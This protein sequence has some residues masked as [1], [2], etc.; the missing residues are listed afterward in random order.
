[1]NDPQPPPAPLPAPMPT[2]R[3]PTPPLGPPHS[4]APRPTALPLT[5]SQRRPP[6]PKVHGRAGSFWKHRPGKTQTH[7]REPPGCGRREGGVGGG[8]GIPFS[9]LRMSC[10]PGAARPAAVICRQRSARH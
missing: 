3:P 6:A 7:A 1:M 2:C 5:P 10:A 4:A 9:P 8:G